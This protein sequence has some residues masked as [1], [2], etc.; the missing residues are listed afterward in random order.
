MTIETLHHILQW[1]TLINVIV[2]IIWFVVFAFAHDCVYRMHGRLFKISVEQFDA[3]HYAVF[4]FY[5]VVVVALN[6]APLLAL[7]IIR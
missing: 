6:L 2:L 4:G 1:S 3:I 5:K 7:Y